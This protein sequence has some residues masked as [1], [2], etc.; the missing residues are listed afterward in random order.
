[1][2]AAVSSCGH[3]PATTPGHP[4]DPVTSPS[5]DSAPDT[6][7]ASSASSTTGDAGHSTEKTAD[8]PPKVVLHTGDS[9]V[10]YYA[11]L[12]K[13]LAPHFESL[14]A[15]Y[16]QDAV[17]SAAIVTFDRNDHFT[18]MLASQNP[19]LVLI[20]LGA[21]D[22]FLPSPQ[23][24]AKNIASIAK[25]TEGRRCF[26]MGPPVWKKDTGIVEVIRQNCAPC[27]FFDASSLKL[28]RRPDGIHPDDKGGEAWATAFWDFYRA[29]PAA[30]TS[31]GSAGQPLMER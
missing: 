4:S 18:K 30:S 15:K 22:V 5:V 28:E 11:C 14:G 16:V 31:A 6:S 19:D 21:N 1:M 9:M 17:T 12:E 7:A 2:V 13:A 29:Q 8:S 10:G 23:R 3:A 27:V 24:L 25:K 20:T 26:W